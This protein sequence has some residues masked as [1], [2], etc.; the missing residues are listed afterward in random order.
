MLFMLKITLNMAE[1]IKEIETRLEKLQEEKRDLHTE[2][3]RLLSKPHKTLWIITA[4]PSKPDHLR[5][6][7]A[8]F[9]TKELA[10]SAIGKGSSY[11][12]DNNVHWTYTVKEELTHNISD[13]LI[14]D[15]NKTPSHFPYTG[16]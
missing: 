8:C 9:T 13:R 10:E 16:W 7:V 4:T 1:R 3:L 15:L 6:T 11:D 14:Y 5:H 12:I 2:K